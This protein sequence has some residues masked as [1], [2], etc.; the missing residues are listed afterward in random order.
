M[1]S[2]GLSLES[3]ARASNLRS[4]SISAENPAGDE[5]AGGR[6]ASQLGPGRKGKP[7]LL[8]LKPGS[9]HT[10]AEIKGSGCI[11]HVWMTLPLEPE[12]LRGAILRVY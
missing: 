6:E 7:C 3:L 12:F 2:V 11:R 10:L 4:R 1:M 9:T 8:S 5:G